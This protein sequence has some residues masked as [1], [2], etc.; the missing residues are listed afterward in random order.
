MLMRLGLINVIDADPGMKVCGEAATGAHGQKLYR[1]PARRRAPRPAPARHDRR[2]TARAIR[3]EFS[4]AKV[5]LISHV[6]PGEEIYAAFAAGA[7]AFVLK[8]IES[9]ELVEV[10]RKVAR[11][12]RHIP[13]EIGAQLA[14]RVPQSDL[15]EREREV[16]HLVVRGRRNREIAQQLGISEATVKA[17]VGNVLLKL[18]VSHRTEAVSLAIERGMVTVG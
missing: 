17:H 1:G 12:Q 14:A 2:R 13:A 3:K 18:G 11:G 5:V 6:A 4:D 15:T 10:I 16:L 8:T 9:E 7:Q